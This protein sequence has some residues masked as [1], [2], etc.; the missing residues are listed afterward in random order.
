LYGTPFWSYP[1]QFTLVTLIKLKKPKLCV[2]RKRETE[3]KQRENKVFVIFF[4][5]KNKLP[6]KEYKKIIKYPV[7]E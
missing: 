6:Q 3:E 2:Q 5:K 1:S 4:F 7:T